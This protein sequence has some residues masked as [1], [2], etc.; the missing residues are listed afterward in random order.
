MPLFI[1][2]GC[3]YFV[4]LKTGVVDY[5]EPFVGYQVSCSTEGADYLRKQIAA[6][7]AAPAVL[8]PTASA[9]PASPA[10]RLLP[11]SPAPAGNADAWS[12][13][14]SGPVR[15]A[16]DGG[17]QVFWDMTN[18]CNTA[19][20]VRYCFRA[21]FEAAGDPNLCR[22]QEMRTHEIAPN[23]N[24]TFDFNLMPA[25]TVLTDGRTVTSNTLLVSGF[26]CTG[27]NF[28]DAYFDSDGS[29]RSRGC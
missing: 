6:M 28:P 17:I 25:G 27:G 5:H 2:D 29:F 3:P 12:R 18:S 24:L 20:I 15:R 8:P 13:C 26:A 21:Q 19:V 4:D 23:G 10:Q 1:K 11:T 14:I 7:L 9:P 16:P 22:R